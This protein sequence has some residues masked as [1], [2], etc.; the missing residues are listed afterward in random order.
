REA[1]AAKQRDPNMPKKPMTSYLLF[2]NEMRQKIREENPNA[3]SQETVV[4]LGEEWSKLSSE[5]R[6][7]YTNKSQELRKLYAAK[8]VDY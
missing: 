7:K 6:E 4:K 8:M 5:E 3:S 2:S 1:E